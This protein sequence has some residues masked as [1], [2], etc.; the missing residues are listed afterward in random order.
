MWWLLSGGA[1]ARRGP[2]QT[3]GSPVT[4]PSASA[5]PGKLGDQQRYIDSDGARAARAAASC[6][7]RQQLRRLLVGCGAVE[8]GH[9]HNTATS[10]NHARPTLSIHMAADEDAMALVPPR[11][12]R[13]DSDSGAKRALFGKG[14]AARL[15]PTGRQLALLTAAALST[16]CLCL[17]VMG[18]SLHGGGSSSRTAVRT[19]ANRFLLAGD[20]G[21][22]GGGSSD[23][24]LLELAAEQQAALLNV[25]LILAVA[26][27]EP[28]E[29]AT[30]R[31]P[32]LQALMPA[33]SR[34]A[35]GVEVLAAA[36]HWFEVLPPP[37]A[38]GSSGGSA[39]SASLLL[40][41]AD[42]RRLAAALGGQ[43]TLLLHSPGG[44]DRVRSWQ[45]ILHARVTLVQAGAALCTHSVR[46]GT[47]LHALLGC[48]GRRAG[49]A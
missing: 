11:L 1:A 40:R 28:A 8:L 31:E 23:G 27:V 12:S 48:S 19:T 26:G 6:Q 36:T 21:G 9:L 47:H 3:L 42:A 7:C 17:A 14:P 30:L 5:H 4:P 46:P 22:S 18:A 44:G 41:P 15:R 39:V 38:G 35:G 2:E 33:A 37:A 49:T 45:G 25:S 20:D 13:H 10:S 32:L 43:P 24:S 16:M 29:L 34:A